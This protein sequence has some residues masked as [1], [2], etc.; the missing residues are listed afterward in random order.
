MVAASGAALALHRQLALGREVRF[1]D[2]S[3]RAGRLSPPVEGA[4]FND[5]PRS[6]IH[7]AGAPRRSGAVDPRTALI[8][9]KRI[10]HNRRAGPVAECPKPA[11]AVLVDMAG[12][13]LEAASLKAASGQAAAP[14]WPP[15]IPVKPPTPLPPWPPP[16]PRASAPTPLKARAP[17]TRSPVRDRLIDGRMITFPS[18]FTSSAETV[19]PNCLCYNAD[20]SVDLL[21]SNCRTSRKIWD[22]HIRVTASFAP[23]ILSGKHDENIRNIFI[24]DNA[25]P[26][27]N[28]VVLLG[29][30]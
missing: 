19:D 10:R 21:D 7:G 22:C 30:G 24:S 4:K 5:H 13:G 11:D 12:V 25:D 29:A 27:R 6:P 28:F 1:P 3:S 18:L 15:T 20:R 26:A 16:P 8:L 9:A 2:G 17:A 23:V 14:W